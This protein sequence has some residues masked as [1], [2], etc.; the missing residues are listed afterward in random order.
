MNLN[1]LNK[2]K[3]KMYRSTPTQWHITHPNFGTLAFAPTY[4]E[5]KEMLGYY[6]RI[7]HSL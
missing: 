1:P 4:E 2:P 3:L 5:T 6:L 7:F